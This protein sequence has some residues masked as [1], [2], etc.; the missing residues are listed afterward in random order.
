MMSSRGWGSW[1][2]ASASVLLAVL[3]W[4]S[5]MQAS[6]NSTIVIVPGHIWVS[7][8]KK[9]SD[10]LGLSPDSVYALD[11]QV[12]RSL[13]IPRGLHV[14][15]AL[16]NGSDLIAV[17]GTRKP[18]PSE[19]KMAIPVV[20]VLSVDDGEIARFDSAMLAS[21][22]PNGTNLAFVFGVRRQEL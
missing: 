21:W 5:R 7:E 4:G 16:G 14:D 20:S 11:G 6:L 2:T 8:G 3:P 12:W 9:L 19:G 1:I 13:A 22:S 10:V 18:A 15:E 17:A